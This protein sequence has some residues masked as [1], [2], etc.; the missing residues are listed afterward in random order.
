MPEMQL[1]TE[2]HMVTTKDGWTLVAHRA[3]VADPASAGEPA[4]VTGS[5]V[6]VVPGYGTN[7][8]LFGARPGGR[9]FLEALA[10]AGLDAWTVDLRGQGMSRRGSAPRRFGMAQQAFGDLPAILDY[11]ATLL[12]KRKLAAVGCSLGGSLLYAYAA[13]HKG[14]R[15]ERLVTI[16]APLRIVRPHVAVAVAGLLG[17]PLANLPIRGTR[18]MA[19]HALPLLPRHAPRALSIYM[20][21][22][23]VDLSQVEILSQFVDDPHVGVSRELVRWVRRGRLVVDGLDV[24]RALQGLDMPLLVV[25]AYG[26]GI[27]SPESCKSVVSVLGQDKVEELMIGG[28]ELRVAH[29][30]LFVSQIADEQVFQPIAGWLLRP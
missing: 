3:L 5:P 16:G 2:K 24:A 10:Q 27:V 13:R 4:P 29:A 18:F 1:P 11:I 15:L 6:L 21:P 8:M 9:C 7:S 23:L 14:G 17:A 28:P 20:N 25:M 30:D 22:D 26:D 12:G 19:R